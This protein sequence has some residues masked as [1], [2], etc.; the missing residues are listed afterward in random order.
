MACIYYDIVLCFQYYS[1]LSYL[2]IYY[3]YIFI[4]VCAH[5]W[6]ITKWKIKSFL[7]DILPYRHQIAAFDIILVKYAREHPMLI[8]GSNLT[9]PQ[10][11]DHKGMYILYISI[12]KYIDIYNII[13]KIIVLLF[14]NNIFYFIILYI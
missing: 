12:Y 9:S 6:G 8:V 4:G 5:A 10:H 13:I 1:M 2:N 3:I 11:S 14:I 7:T